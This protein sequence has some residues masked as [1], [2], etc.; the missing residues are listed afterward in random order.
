MTATETP[1]RFI[2]AS[3]VNTP[4][5]SMDD[6]VVVDSQEAN[7]GNLEGIV[8]DPQHRQVRYV[9]VKSRRAFKSRHYLV[10]LMSATLDAQHRTLHVDVE[11]TEVDELADDPADSFPVFSDD[12][13]ITAMFAA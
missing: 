1:L 5:G 12:D 7:V 11:P 9:V 8:V 4:A 6:V 2:S 13:L 3:R 10:P